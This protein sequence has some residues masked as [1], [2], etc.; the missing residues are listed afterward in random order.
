MVGDKPRIKEVRAY[1]ETCRAFEI[2]WR[3]KL[4]R[5]ELRYDRAFARLKLILEAL[6]RKPGAGVWGV[7]D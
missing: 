4:Y 5:T 2:T 6:K 7:W 3:G 1:N